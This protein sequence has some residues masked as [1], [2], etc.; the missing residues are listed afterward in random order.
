MDDNED[1]TDEAPMAPS[2]FSAI[3]QK[4]LSQNNVRPRIRPKISRCLLARESDKSRPNSGRVAAKA[5]LPAASSPFAAERKHKAQSSK[6][7]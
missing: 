2:Q 3:P 5:T 1:A 7:A 6:R 4:R